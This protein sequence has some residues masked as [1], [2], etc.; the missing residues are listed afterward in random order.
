M[1]K[2]KNEIL[3]HLGDGPMPMAH[4]REKEPMPMK[5][6]E[7]VGF[8]NPNNPGQI[9]ARPKPDRKPTAPWRRGR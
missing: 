3:H 4:S 1:R 8:T 6:P 5:M 9:P 7:R 2:G